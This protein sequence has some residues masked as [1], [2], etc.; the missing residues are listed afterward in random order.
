MTI[1]PSV[2][3]SGLLWVCC[4]GSECTAARIGRGEN[5][6]GRVKTMMRPL[7]GEGSRYLVPLFLEFQEHTNALESLLG[8]PHPISSDNSRERHLYPPLPPTLCVYC[9]ACW[10]IG[11]SRGNSKTGGWG[12]VATREINQPMR[13]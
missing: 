8:P 3:G 12:S 10:E 4:P 6:H 1:V 13:N 2:L 9:A 11:E 5:W 7:I